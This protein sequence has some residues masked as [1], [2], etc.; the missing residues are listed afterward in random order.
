M[1][2]T[3]SRINTSI[4][5]RVR[6]LRERLGVSQTALG[7]K[8]GVSFQQMQKYESGINR[9]SAASLYEISKVLSVPI[10]Y[11]FEK[12]QEPAAP[13]EAQGEARGMRRD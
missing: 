5:T 1:P 12:D 11:F 6:L 9:I 3:V 2:K 8:L 10:G 7:E 13:Q 4:G